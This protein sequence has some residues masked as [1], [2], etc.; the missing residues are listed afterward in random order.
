MIVLK[1]KASVGGCTARR[2]SMTRE[3]M[4]DYS[5]LHGKAD[6]AHNIGSM[7]VKT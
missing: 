2:V 7:G 5:D 1:D 6:M 4:G 3:E